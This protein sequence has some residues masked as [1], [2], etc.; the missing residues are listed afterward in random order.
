MIRPLSLETLDFDR[1]EAALGPPPPVAYAAA[2]A[3]PASAPLY[4]ESPCAH[5]DRPSADALRLYV[6]IPYC[7]YRCTFCFFAVRVGAQHRE[8][9]RYVNA[10]GRE[11]EWAEPGTPLSQL[12]VGGGTPTA[13]PP[14]L[15]EEVLASIFERLPSQGSN[16]HV[17]E[18]SPE[19][20]TPGHVEVLRRQG[21]GRSQHGDA[22]PGG[23]S[24]G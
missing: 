22:E 19:S 14:E 16:V 21:V 18:A 23:R 15:L 17:V 8:M 20:I 12:F 1:I 5:R 4:T 13:L 3:Y 24:P 9:Q 11:L 6:H 10:L 7:N 2:H